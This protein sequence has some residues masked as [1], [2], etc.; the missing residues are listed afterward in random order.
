M[1]ACITS[2]RSKVRWDQPRPFVERAKT[3]GE[4]TRFA[5]RE[6]PLPRKIRQRGDK[7][8]TYRR[9]IKSLSIFALPKAVG[10]RAGE[11][12]ADLPYLFLLNGSLTPTFKR[13]LDGV[14]PVRARA[15]TATAAADIIS[16][17]LSWLSS[18][19]YGVSSSVLITILA[20]GRYGRTK[21]AKAVPHRV[22]VRTS[23]GSYTAGTP[24]AE[25][26]SSSTELRNELSPCS[27]VCEYK[28]VEI[29]PFL[30][31]QPWL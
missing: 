13:L 29:D 24:A 3:R 7:S 18:T 15:P 9:A 26:H 2:S 16:A 21:L 20:P 12:Y 31:E 19:Q 11:G 8:V 25:R 23:A 28:A 22:R 1:K 17:T 5:P 10:R 4:G 27:S 6:D 30:L 14:I